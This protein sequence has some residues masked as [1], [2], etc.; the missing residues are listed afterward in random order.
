M[1]TLPLLVWAGAL[2][3]IYRYYHPN[4][5]PTSRLHK[6][7]KRVRVCLGLAIVALLTSI[8]YQVPTELSGFV[9]SVQ[10]NQV[11]LSA[12]RERNR[13]ASEIQRVRQMIDAL[14]GVD[15]YLAYLKCQQSPSPEKNYTTHR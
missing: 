3:Y 7:N 14:G 6:L 11:A 1:F 5:H 4:N 2:A 9:K 13:Q 12:D 8:A 10:E 15:N